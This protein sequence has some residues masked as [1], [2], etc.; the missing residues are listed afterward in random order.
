MVILFEM[1]IV[2][3]I[4]NQIK[5]EIYRNQYISTLSDRKFL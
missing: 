1:G 2:L 4:S 3:S 5:A